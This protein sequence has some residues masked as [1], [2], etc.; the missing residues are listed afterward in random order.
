T[1]GGGEASSFFSFFK[2]S[3]SVRERI[4]KERLKKRLKYLA[5]LCGVLGDEREWARIDG[6][7]CVQEEI[8]L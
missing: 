1:C 2:S 4:M 3:C 6:V 5:F 7:V 8:G